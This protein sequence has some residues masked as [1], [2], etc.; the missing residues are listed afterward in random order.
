MI[1]LSLFLGILL[2]MV[3]GWLLLRL[4]EGKTPAL[5]LP[6]RIAISWLTGST[7][8]LALS[9]AANVTVGIPFSR[10][11][12]LVAWLLPTMLAFEEVS[13]LKIPLFPK[14]KRFLKRLVENDFHPTECVH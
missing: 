13:R 4:L 8:T 14:L 12:F 7:L 5:L 3:T 1:F 11:G 10:I 2:P 6:E 9:F